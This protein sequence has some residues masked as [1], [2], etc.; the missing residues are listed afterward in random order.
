MAN[1]TITQVSANMKK[2][3]YSDWLSESKL[4]QATARQ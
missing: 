2:K 1:T 3:H 4:N